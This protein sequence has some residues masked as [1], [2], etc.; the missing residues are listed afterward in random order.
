M[1]TS[2]IEEIALNA[3]SINTNDD[4]KKSLYECVGILDNFL[5]QIQS[6]KTML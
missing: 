6:N 5:D 3:E 2:I 4:F 1:T